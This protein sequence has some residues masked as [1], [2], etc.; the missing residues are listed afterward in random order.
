MLFDRLHG[1]ELA[2]EVR[3]HGWAFRGPVSVPVRWRA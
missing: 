1:L 3:F 2:G